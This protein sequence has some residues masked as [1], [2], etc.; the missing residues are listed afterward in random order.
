MKQN[1]YKLGCMNSIAVGVHT[2]LISLS[3]NFV[4]PAPFPKTQNYISITNY[5]QNVWRTK[6]RM[7]LYYI[8]FL[9]ELQLENVAYLSVYQL[10][11]LWHMH[12]DTIWQHESH[13]HILSYICKTQRCHY[14]TIPPHH[15]YKQPCIN[16][17]SSAWLILHLKITLLGH[18]LFSW[19]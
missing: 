11:S 9:M 1:T 7:W 18:Y 13:R 6:Y 15:H 10:I 16:L 5:F 3:I 14:N 2:P 12:L 4:N 8:K 19:K 17:V